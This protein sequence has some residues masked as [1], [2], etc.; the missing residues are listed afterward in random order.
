MLEVAKEL[1]QAG[2]FNQQAYKKQYFVTTLSF[3]H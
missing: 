2:T 1:D 3:V